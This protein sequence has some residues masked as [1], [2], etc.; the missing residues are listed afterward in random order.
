MKIDYEKPMIEYD[1]YELDESIAAGC[2]TIVTLAPMPYEG[3]EICSEYAQPLSLF[4]RSNGTKYDNW[5]DSTSCTCYFSSGE[6][7]MLTS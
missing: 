5:N 6:I 4:D 7:P 1:E 3:H 2:T